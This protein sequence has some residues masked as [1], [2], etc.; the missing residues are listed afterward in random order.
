MNSGRSARFMP[1]NEHWSGK[2]SSWFASNQQRLASELEASCPVERPLG[3][4]ASTLRRISGSLRRVLQPTGIC[5]VVRANDK[6]TLSDIATALQQSLEPA[7]RWTT[8]WQVTSQP[9]CLALSEPSAHA[10]PA[11]RALK[12]LPARRHRS[13]VAR[14][15]STLAI[16]TV[17]RQRVC[18]QGAS[19]ALSV[20]MRVMLRPD[21][22]L[23]LEPPTA[24]HPLRCR[25]WPAPPYRRALPGDCP[26]TFINENL[27]IGETVQEASR[28]DSPMA[29]QSPGDDG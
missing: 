3:R 25:H 10:T 12:L 2:T 8:A 13:A 28:I 18:R 7:F 1:S 21:L 20:F 19:S 15:R 16:C 6:T 11:R 4:F 14:L 22:I 26:E 29:V 24:Q 5:V 23:V 9:S 17:D 27:S